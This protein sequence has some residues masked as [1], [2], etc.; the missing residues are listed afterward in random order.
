[1][2]INRINV[3]DE[4]IKYL[5]TNIVSGLWAP[6]QK[7]D[8]ESSLSKQLNVSRASIHAAI[9]QLIATGV[10]E[11]FQ[12]KGTFVRS[13]S[14]M[15]LKI[16]L[17]NRANDVSTR[18]MTEFRIIMEGQICKAIAPHIS[19]ETIRQLEKYINM[20]DEHQNQPQI[21]QK[22]DLQFHRTLYFATQNELIIQSMNVV[23]DEMERW[24]I[25]HFNP[26]SIKRTI[27]EHKQIAFYLSQHDGDSAKSA[28]IHHLAGA[29]SVPPFDLNDIENSLFSNIEY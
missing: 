28:M 2:G 12:G 21:T 16:R 5:E 29:P 6:G 24:H 4:V 17:T 19:D 8:S 26:D 9:Q 18:K 7:I 20:M 15:E 3:T 27:S 25:M 23:C 10:L 13:I 11:S 1:M 22:C 14:L